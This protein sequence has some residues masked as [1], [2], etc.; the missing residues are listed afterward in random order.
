MQ[1]ISE[2]AVVTAP[3]QQVFEFLKVPS[4]IELLLPKDKISDFQ[5]TEEQCSFKAQGG[6]TISLIFVTHDEPNKLNMK[7]G[8]K[9]PFTYTLSIVLSEN[10]T[11]TQGHIEFNADINMFMKLVVEKPLFS[12]FNSMTEKLKS[13]F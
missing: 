3:I 5:S 1:I 12:L 2:K 11:E 9:A 8:E 4:N 6:V 13:Q 7:S 10:G